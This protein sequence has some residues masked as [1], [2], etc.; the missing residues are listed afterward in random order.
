MALVTSLWL[1]RSHGGHARIMLVLGLCYVLSVVVSQLYLGVHY[2]SG[3]LGGWCAGFVW[4][5]GL[6]IAMR[7]GRLDL[8][9]SECRQ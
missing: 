5:H 6:A 1:V 3:V 4:C 9:S 2:P 7:R 8:C